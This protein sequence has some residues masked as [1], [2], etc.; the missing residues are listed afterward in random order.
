MWKLSNFS[1]PNIIAP[2]G[3][4]H[5]LM[6]RRAALLVLGLFGLIPFLLMTRLKFHKP[7]IALMLE[8]STSTTPPEDVSLLPCQSPVRR[9]IFAKTHKT[10]STTVQNIL[11]RFGHR[12]GLSFAF[13]PGKKEHRFRLARQMDRAVAR[14]KS[15]GGFD[16]FAFHAAWNKQKV[17]VAFPLLSLRILRAG[18]YAT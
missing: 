17:C 9:V 8:T 4:R 11:L 5:G 14:G 15:R 18:K 10:A 3:I 13:P 12:N 6:N 16:I 2:V 7:R 1:N